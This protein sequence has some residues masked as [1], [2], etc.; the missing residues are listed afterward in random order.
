[1]HA[2]NRA[3]RTA[4]AG[5]YPADDNTPMRIALEDAADALLCARAHLRADYQEVL[6]LRYWEKLSW[7]AAGSRLHR[8]AAAARMLHT[9]AL[10]ALSILL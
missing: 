8:S 6:Q 5:L 3:G 9:R 10:H 2:R 7:R 1:M 4:T